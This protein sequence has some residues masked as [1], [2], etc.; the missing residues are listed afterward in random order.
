[1]QMDQNIDMVVSEFDR[2][3]R[4]GAST[5]GVSKV[6]RNEIHLASRGADFFSRSLAAFRIAAND[7]NMNAK[8]GE[9]ICHSPADTPVISAAK[10][11]CSPPF[12]VPVSPVINS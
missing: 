4:H 3:L 7:Q 1:M 10:A 12:S 8:P 2:F 9:L 11:I 6:G 5:R